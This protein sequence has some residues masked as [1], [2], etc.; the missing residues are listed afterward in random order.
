MTK[1]EVLALQERLNEIGESQRVTGSLLVE[2]G[3]YGRR[4]QRVHQA[5]LDRDEEVPTLTPPAA[6]AWWQSRAV[7]GIGGSF[8]AFI[9]ARFGLDIGS[10]Q[11][12]QILLLVAQAA[13]LV[14]AAIGTLRN[15]APIDPTLVARVGDHD[16]RLPVRPVGGRQPDRKDPRGH[17]E[18]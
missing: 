13:G 14:V 11:I 9:L 5:Y 16:Y 6:E 10:E 17:F 7:I 15:R 8:L 4:T 18:S 1:S 12:V 3:V 2:D